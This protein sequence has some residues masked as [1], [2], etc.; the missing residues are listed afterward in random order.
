M[1]SRRSGIFKKSYDK[2][3][4]CRL[5]RAR[6][7]K[8]FKCAVFLD[9]RIHF[10]P[11]CNNVSMAHISYIRNFSGI[12][13]CLLCVAMAFGDTQSRNGLQTYFSESYWDKYWILSSSGNLKIYRIAQNYLF[14][15]IT[16][17]VVVISWW[18]SR[19][20]YWSHVQGSKIQEKVCCPNTEF[21]QGRVWAV[22]SL[23]FMTPWRWE[24]LV[25]NCHYSLRNNPE[26]RTSHLLCSRS[27]EHVL[28][29]SC[30]KFHTVYTKT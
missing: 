28:Q 3:L 12:L 26:E 7:E 11:S 6:S 15:V 13:W 18:H 5:R 29:D 14:C 16:W 10:I 9:I 21:I 2:W 8:V 24:T 23:E 19:T 27:L 17:L 4:S 25:R 1:P 30:Y 20:T 22:L